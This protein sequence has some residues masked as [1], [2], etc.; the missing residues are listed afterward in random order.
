MYKMYLKPKVDKP[1]LWSSL[2][3]ILTD[4]FQAILDELQKKYETDRDALIYFTINQDSLVNGLRSSVHVLKENT[5]HSMV[6][7]VISTFHRYVNSNQ[8]IEL[9][10]TFECFFK[11]VSGIHVNYPNHKRKATPL[12]TLVGHKTTR[13]SSFLSGGLLDPPLGHDLDP[14]MF[15][16]QCLLICLVLQFI[17]LSDPDT[18]QLVEPFLY[19]KRS[20]HLKI[21]AA[22]ILKAQMESFCK[23]ANIVLDGPH[24]LLGTAKL[25]S[26]FHNCQIIIISSMDGVVPQMNMFPAK[27]NFD[28]IR[29]YLFAQNNHVQIIDNVAS[30]WRTQNKEICLSCKKFVS[31]WGK[32]GNHKCY[33]ASKCTFCSGILQTKETVINNNENFTFCDSKLKLDAVICKKC[34]N[35]LG[36]HKCYQNHMQKCKKNLMPYKCV[37]CQVMVAGNARFGHNCGVILK[38]CPVCFKVTT[39]EHDC[40]ITKQVETKTWPVI[41]TLTCS[42]KSTSISACQNCYV[43]KLD[44]AKV[45]KIPFNLFCKDKAYQ[46]VVCDNH[47]SGSSKVT[48]NV[49]SLW[50]EVKRFIFQRKIFLDDVLL[51]SNS[52]MNS[53]EMKPS[54]YCKDPQP[55]TQAQPKNKKTK[56]VSSALQQIGEGVYKTAEA[57]FFQFIVLGNLTNCTIVTDNDQIMLKLLEIFLSFQVQPQVVQKGRQIFC[58]ELTQFSVRFL[59]FSHYAPGCLESWSDSFDCSNRFCCFPET[60]NADAYIN[61]TRKVHIEFSTFVDFGDSN[62][63]IKMKKNFYDSIIQPV[64]VKYFL[65]EMHNFKH[66]N[67][68]QVVMNFLNES[69]K[70]QELL[71]YLFQKECSHP[72]HPFS[73]HI[74]S[75]SSYVHSLCQYYALNNYQICTVTSPYNGTPAPVSAGEYE[76]TSYLAHQNPTLQI[77]NA[78]NNPSGQH[79]FGKVL[80]D[81]YSSINKT[82]YSYKGCFHHC[83]E[84]NVCLDKSIVDTK[85]ELAERKRAIDQLVDSQTLQMFPLEVK[86]IEI[87]WHCQWQKFKETNSLRLE[88]FWLETGLPKNRPLI[89]LVPRASIRGGFLECYQLKAKETEDQKISWIDA[90]SLYSYI[91]LQ[92]PLP[93]GSYKVLTFFDLKDKCV[94]NPEDGMFYYDT[95]SMECDIA[96][97]E[98]LAPSNLDRPFLSFRINDQFVF[99]SNCKTCAEKKS[100]APCKH[101]PEFR[102]FTSVWPVI[103]LAYAVH[104]L[105]YK[106]VSWLEVHHYKNNS[107][108][109]R[110]FVQVLASQKLRTSGIWKKFKS[111]E[112]K[113]HYCHKL[114]QEMSFVD[115]GLILTPANCHSNSVKENYVKLCLNSLYGRFAI[116]SNNVEHI[117]CKSVHDIEV[118]TSNPNSEILDFF[119]VNDSIIE[120]VVE[121]KKLVTAS[122]HSNMYFTAIIN[123]RA[124]I[125]IYDLSRQLED[126]NCKILSIDTDSIC[127]THPPNFTYPFNLSIA[128]GSFKHVLGENTTVKAFYSL[129]VRSYVII[130]TDETGCEKYLT[131]VK[132]MSLASHN[133]DDSLMP[134][135]FQQFIDSRFKNEVESI[136]I[137][138]TRKKIDK[139]TKSF[140]QI[141]TNHEFSNE[142]HCKRFIIP[143]DES[144]RTY[145]YGYKESH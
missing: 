100:T 77:E 46:S 82:I 61:E 137:P 21:T 93:I 35:T 121:K 38:R 105:G 142:V 92:S 40:L 90:N 111:P 14:N 73:S 95:E 19:K 135:V 113:L 42:F 134:G 7:N 59:N 108:V 125:F 131:K 41:G 85:P 106:I 56:V 128:F 96:M 69:F 109:L 87:M 24:D 67:F 107:C 143:N 17:R 28:L 76:Y 50:V 104:K 8:S 141:I 98:I 6:S 138:Q 99:L 60:L 68:F 33:A 47:A 97:V 22:E 78:F 39:K 140:A 13:K 119:T 36:S 110:D 64:D 37:T 3:N 101:K 57:K 63:L 115:A 66:N 32:K 123:A 132:G 15:Q 16:N 4:A 129:G 27:L 23:L 124:R 86:R 45:L 89:R 51:E 43:A 55:F 65:L 34:D 117:F 102:S 54:Q 18:K 48:T 139:Q 133:L 12:R 53:V 44:R 25:F 81:G 144:Y 2:E 127:F 145:S 118:H 136:F 5:I 126:L 94:L 72:I 103:E 49:I 11:V 29:V 91:A 52:T 62:D 1:I 83:H 120:M 80:A 116:H 71:S 88:Q 114:N 30:F 10:H 75:C 84:D 26:E 9:N 20:L 122:R 74:V 58:L 70:L 130:Y 112:E 31:Y 79:R